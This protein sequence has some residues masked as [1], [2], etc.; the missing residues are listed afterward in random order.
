MHVVPGIP[1]CCLPVSVQCHLYPEHD[2]YYSLFLKRVF[3]YTQISSCRLCFWLF[4]VCGGSWAHEPNLFGFGK[5]AM[6]GEY[7][8]SLGG[9]CG[10]VKS[11][12]LFT[13][14]NIG[15]PLCTRACR[16]MSFTLATLDECCGFWVLQFLGCRCALGYAASRPSWCLH[17]KAPWSLRDCM[18]ASDAC[19][20]IGNVRD[21]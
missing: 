10:L 4:M 15:L 7:Q 3:G 12:V 11:K 9:N 18:R 5:H 2:L 16:I 21:C 14:A 6:S 20:R 13:L 19:C 17:W 1:V 8:V